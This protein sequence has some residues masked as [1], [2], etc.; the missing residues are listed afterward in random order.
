MLCMGEVFVLCMGVDVEK[1]ARRKHK[2]EPSFVTLGERRGPW[3]RTKERSRIFTFWERKKNI[4]IDENG[5]AK[6]KSKVLLVF[7]E[8]TLTPL[9]LLH[10]MVCDGPRLHWPSK[11]AVLEKGSTRITL[12]SP[13]PLQDF[14]T[15]QLPKEE[16]RLR[17][18]FLWSQG[19]RWAMSPLTKRLCLLTLGPFF[20][21]M[22]LVQ[23][24]CKMLTFSNYRK[25]SAKPSRQ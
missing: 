3:V 5:L 13:N 7:Y 10:F 6:N 11:I 14:C 1:R 17:L 19:V 20:W 15:L 25:W 18:C 22:K 24:T 9:P 23:L 12:I 8:L 2:S 16:T 4:L 21:F